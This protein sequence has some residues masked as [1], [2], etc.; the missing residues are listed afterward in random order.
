MKLLCDEDIG[1]SVP[2]ALK[3]VGYDVTSIYHEKWAGREDTFWLEKAGQLN[4]LIFSCNKR[5]LL[6]DAERKALI[7]NNVGIIFLTSGWEHPA[8]VLRLLLNKWDK[9]TYIHSNQTRPF[10]LFLSPNGKISNSYRKFH[11]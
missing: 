10:A 7:D 2:K 8:N 11:L 6:V 4:W 3:L 1:T 9:I 5:I